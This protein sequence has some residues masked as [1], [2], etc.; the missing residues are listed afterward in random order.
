MIYLKIASVKFSET[1]T[2]DPDLY[3]GRF[4]RTYIENLLKNSTDDVFSVYFNQ[5]ELGSPGSPVRITLGAYQGP[6]TRDDGDYFPPCP[7][8][9][10][11]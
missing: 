2:N 3:M 9:C 11:P 8:N 10:Y 1:E 7:P 4:S 6:G 5:E